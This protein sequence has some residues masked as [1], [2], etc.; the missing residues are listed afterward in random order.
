MNHYLR[1]S[2]MPASSAALFAYHAR[3]GALPRLVPPW[4]NVRIDREPA[5]L[6]DGERA[7]IVLK[8]GPLQR[9]WVAEHFDFIDGRQFRDRQLQGP[10][11]SWVHTHRMLDGPILN[12]SILEDEIEYQIP[13]GPLGR[14]MLGGKIARDIAAVFS[15]RHARTTFDLLRHERYRDVPRLTVAITGASGSIGSDLA[16]FLTTAGHRVIKLVRHTARG[17]DE[18]RWNADTGEIDRDV[19]AECDVIVHL[20]G[21]NIATRWSDAAKRKIRESRVDT[22]RKL[23]EYLAKCDK[24]PRALICA[25]AIGYYGN[26]GDEVL[27]ESSTAG[28]NWMAKVCVDW[29]RAT[30]AARDSGI[31]VVN[32]R[33]GIVLSAR[34]G[35]LAKML[36]PTKFGV[37]G[38]V[39]SGEQWM[40][41]IAMDDHVGVLHES[42]FRDDWH[43]PINSVTD[44]VRQSEFIHT[45][46]TVLRRP[47]FLP[48][49]KSGVTTLFGEMGHN[50]LLGSTR[51]EP[52]R[53][54]DANFEWMLPTLERALRFELGR[55]AE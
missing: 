1:Q 28:D 47:T 16:P 43:G 7:E 38:R 48:M 11:A 41:W 49:P 22:T 13:A 19:V 27:N 10:F 50:L 30:D 6:K 52:A 21:K 5:S 26:R 53:L 18:A 42:I 46:G 15:F 17:P 32:V 37:A 35:A 33:T 55:M 29:E 25:S 8:L 39:G 44:S 51:V 36:L 20:A 9:R 4:Q 24:R 31:R 2:R 34:H 45:L 54:R 12:E 23:A 14:A 3:P 40:P